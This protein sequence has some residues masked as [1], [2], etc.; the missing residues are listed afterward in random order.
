M[1]LNLI[2]Q[3][4]NEIPRLLYIKEQWFRKE[5]LD[6]RNRCAL[7]LSKIRSSPQEITKPG[8]QIVRSEIRLRMSLVK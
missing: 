5:K 2:E 6:K 4:R 8:E 7:Y 3:K 1:R